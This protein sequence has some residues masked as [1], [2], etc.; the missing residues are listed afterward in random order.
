MIFTDLPAGVAALF[1]LPVSHV[2]LRRFYPTA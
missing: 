2:T 1:H